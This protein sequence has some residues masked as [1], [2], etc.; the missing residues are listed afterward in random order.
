MRDQGS[1]N[2]ALALYPEDLG[3]E[4]AETAVRHALAPDAP[5]RVE[6]VHVPHAIERV[7]LTL[8]PVARFEERDV[9]GLA[10]VADQHVVIAEAFR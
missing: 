4:G 6:E 2:V 1:G 9:E 10:V 8:E 7:A 3:F 5:R